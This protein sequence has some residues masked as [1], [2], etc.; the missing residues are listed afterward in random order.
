[1]TSVSFVIPVFNK[2]KYL[3][4]VLDSLKN[5]KGTFQ[6]EFI[7]VNDGS[8]DNSLLL[9]RSQ[10]KNWKNTKIINQKNKGSASATNVGIKLAKNKYIKFLDADDLILYDATDSLLK[11]IE[12]SEQINLVYGLQRKVNEPKRRR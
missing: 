10:T 6:R 12:R 3:R 11:I 7:F 1:M 5:Q 2:E 9:L 4:F 8:T